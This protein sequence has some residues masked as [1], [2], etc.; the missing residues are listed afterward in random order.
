MELLAATKEIFEKNRRTSGEFQ[1]TVPSEKSYPHQWFWDSCF[2]AITLSHFDIESAKKEI[3]A[4]VAKQFEDGMLPHMI[5][6][7]GENV[8]FQKV[9]WGKEGTS[10]ITQP[11][12]IAYAAWKAS[13]EGWYKDFLSS[14]Y[15][16]LYHYYRY[17]ITDRDPHENHLIGIMNP[18]ES[19]EDNSPRFDAPLGLPPEQTIEENYAKRKEL[20]GQNIKCRFDAP[21]CMRNFFWVKDVPFNCIMIKNLE[22][23]T[24]IAKALGHPNDAEYY[25][26]TASEIAISMKKRMFEDGIY[27]PTYGRDYKKIKAK[28]WA[29]FAPLFAKILSQ[30]EADSLIHNHLLDE[31]QFWTKYPVPTTALDDPAY[32]PNGF[33]R[34]P[35]W[36]ATNWIVCQGL[37]NYGY[38]KEAEAIKEKTEELLQKNGFREQ[39]NPETGEG[40]GARGFTWGGLVLDM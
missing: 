7:E 24:E 21:F 36:M 12:M 27:W 8:D 30:E 37:K 32:D 31:R 11:P 1:Y 4:L 15:R 19:G 25:L 38:Y 23:L 2:H 3:L 20:Y 34:G 18:D 26:E 28:T 35:T 10:S 16:N 14:I 29:I 9:E 17:L 6:W 13:R 39:F 22:V 5:Y 40:Y 33:W